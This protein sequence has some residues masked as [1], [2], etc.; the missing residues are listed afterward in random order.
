MAEVENTV[1]VPAEVPVVVTPVDLLDSK[2]DLSPYDNLKTVLS[3]LNEHMAKTKTLA[4]YV[5]ATMK[6]VDRQ[7]K[8]LDKLRNK[9]TRA[10][11]ERKNNGVQSGITKPVPI[12]DELAAFLGVEPGTMVPRNE[13]TK[14]VSAYV[15]KHE[16]SDPTNRQKFILD[17][18]PE[19]LALKK[20][21]GN[22][23]D[24]VTYFNLQRYLK[25]HYLMVG[26]LSVD[27]PVA[28]TVV[29][30]PVPEPEVPEPVNTNV[31]SDNESVER[32]QHKKKLIL[33]KK[34]GGELKEEP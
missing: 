27:I 17:T 20:L 30:P 26:E 12:T 2:T 24:P 33:R 25:H 1:E 8:D 6:V 28:T 4:T 22:P 13:V 32:K 18:T 9:S 23:T 19:G 34:G 10:K 21:L 15:H 31:V 29:V 5:R 7:S 14:G 11:T 3:I 16:L